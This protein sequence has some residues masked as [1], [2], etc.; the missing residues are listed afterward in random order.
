MDDDQKRMLIEAAV[1][2]REHAYAPHSR[3]QVGAAALGADG[4]IFPGVNVENASFGLTCC[5][6]RVALFAGVAAGERQFE[7]IAI[8]TDGGHAPCGACRQVINELAPDA[9]IFLVDSARENQ[10]T[11]TSIDVLLPHS[12]QFPPEP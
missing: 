2:A 5:A 11:E 9:Q 12:F 6:E 8:A 10:V 7:C 1:A 4:R 3:F